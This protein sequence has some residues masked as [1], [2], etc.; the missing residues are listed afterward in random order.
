M[1]RSEACR[2]LEIKSGAQVTIPMTEILE[3]SGHRWQAK[4][5]TGSHPAETKS[6][7]CEKA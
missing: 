5:K 1:E 2:Q 3:F 7:G 6:I 4:Q